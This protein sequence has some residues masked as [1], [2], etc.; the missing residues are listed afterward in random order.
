MVDVGKIGRMQGVNLGIGTRQ[1]RA[2]ICD[3]LT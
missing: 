2:D 1:L 3:V